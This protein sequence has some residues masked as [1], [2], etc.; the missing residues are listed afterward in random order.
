MKGLHYSLA[1]GGKPVKPHGQPRR[2]VLEHVGRAM[3]L[4]CLLLLLL[5]S[6]QRSAAQQGLAQRPRTGQ[7]RVLP[8]G[9]LRPMYAPSEQEEQL[10]IQ[11]FKLDVLP[12]TNDEFLRFV[13]AHPEWQQGRVQALFADAG[14]LSHWKDA[15]TLGERAHPKQ[16]VTFVSWFAAKAYCQAKG[17]RL[18]SE[19]EWEYAAAASLTSPDARDDVEWQRTILSW[20]AQPAS[21]TLGRVGQTPANVYGIQDLHGLVWEWVLE[22]NSTLV[23]S[24]SRE[25]KNADAARFCGAGAVSASDKGSYAGFMRYA[26]R[27]S[28][29]ARFTTARLGFRCAYNVK[30]KP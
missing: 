30:E 22:F 14:Y 28:L 8:A 27:S 2:Q 1:A 19:L 23:S 13:I 21:M 6:E 17:G 29:E 9:I 16:P 25:G 18:P 10:P 24:D 15:R 3:G 7:A 11:A 12:V 4:P 5:L 26:F 20:Y